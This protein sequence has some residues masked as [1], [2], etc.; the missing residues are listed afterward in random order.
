MDPDPDPGGPK[1]YGSDG[2]AI[3]PQSKRTICSEPVEKAVEYP[4]PG[5]AAA[6]GHVADWGPE[7]LLRVV[8]LHAGQALPR[9]PVIS[10]C[11]ILVCQSLK[12]TV[13]RDFLLLVFFMNLFP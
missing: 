7:V 8:H 13:A 2:S 10:A 6:G 5:A 1:T 12:G 4:D 11:K 3:L 9:V